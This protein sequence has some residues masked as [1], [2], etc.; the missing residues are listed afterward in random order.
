MFNKDQIESMVEML[1]TLDTTTKIYLGCDSVRQLRDGRSV[2]RYAT[3]AIVHK[4]GKNGCRIFSNIS[5]ENDY[6]VKKNRPK[7]RMMNEVQK[8]CELYNELIPFIDEYDVEIHLD[9]N[10]DPKHGSNCA[11]SEAAGYVLGMT[12]VQAK[13]KPDSWA[14]SF[15]A[16]GVVHGRGTTENV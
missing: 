5:Y 2:A 3:V 8:V 15:G 10:T 7:M 6:D 9:I 14:A 12:G 13:L 16:D 4:N 11:A 1:I